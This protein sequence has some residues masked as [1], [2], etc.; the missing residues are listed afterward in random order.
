MVDKVIP[1]L[2]TVPQYNEGI[3]SERVANWQ[4]IVSRKINNV[5]LESNGTPEGTINAPKLSFC[6]DVTNDNLYIKK[7]QLGDST[8]W[9]LI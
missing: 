3:P 9:V 1:P 4:E 5:V 8:G 7:S 2:R 6:F